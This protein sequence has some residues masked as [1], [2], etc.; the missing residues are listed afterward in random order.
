MVWNRRQKGIGN[1]T[2]LITLQT[3]RRY[4]DRVVKFMSSFMILFF[5]HTS[6]C[7]FVK[8][9]RKSSTWTSPMYL[10]F[11]VC[12]SLY[13]SCSKSWPLF[14]RINMLANTLRFKLH[15]RLCFHEQARLE[16]VWVIDTDGSKSLEGQYNNTSNRRWTYLKARR[17]A[18]K[19]ISSTQQN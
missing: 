15:R 6:K 11:L 10:S 8:V 16:G 12:T 9:R 1:R 5:P 19:N 14:L 13:I 3:L 18:D 7:L 17:S 2:Y 4:L